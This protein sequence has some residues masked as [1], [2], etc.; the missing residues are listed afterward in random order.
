MARSFVCLACFL[1][2]VSVFRPA[3]ADAQSADAIGI[4]AQGMAGAFT[5]VADDSTATWWNPAGLATGAYFNAAIEAGDDHHRGVSVAFPALGLSYYRHHINQIQPLGSTA[6]SSGDRQDPGTGDVGLRSLDVSQF[7]VTVGQ[8]IASHLVVASTLKLVTGAD[9]THGDLDVGAMASFSGARLGVTVRN[10]TRPTLGAG[11]AAL[12][13]ERTVRAGFALTAPGR[14][15][16][17]ATV[18]IDAD[19]TRVPS[20]TGDERRVAAGVEIW[21]PSRTVAA[22]AGV[23]AS[24]LGESRRKVGVGASVAVR[25]GAYLEVQY[26]HIGMAEPSKSVGIAVKVTF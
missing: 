20:G 15:A 4:R 8:S 5:A 2:V 26:S 13:L 19:V 24:T 17:S 3:P 16:G 11:D 7:G 1:L 6:A 21:D 14:R 22:R 10:L 12:R 23:S 25:S 9:S 18:A